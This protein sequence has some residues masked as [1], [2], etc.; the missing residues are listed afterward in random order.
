MGKEEREE[1]GGRR[2]ERERGERGERRVRKEWEE[3]GRD[4]KVRG[5]EG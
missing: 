2:K 5:K 4:H 1:G 3:H